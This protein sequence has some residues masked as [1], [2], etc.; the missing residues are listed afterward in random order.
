M[1]PYKYILPVDDWVHHGVEE[2]EQL[3]NLGEVVE[4]HIH[5]KLKKKMK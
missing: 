4:G 5:V 1:L 3:G 2:G